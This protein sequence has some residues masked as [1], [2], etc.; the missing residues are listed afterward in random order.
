[1]KFNKLISSSIL[2]SSLILSL[3]F[4]ATAKN[5]VKEDF[6]YVA[7][8]DS[9][10]AGQTPYKELK[11]GYPDYLASRFA[12]SQ[13]NIELENYGFSGYRTTDIL[14]ELYYPTNPKYASLRASIKDAELV[15]IGIGA[16][17]LLANLTKI[18][19][20]PALAP[21]VIQGIGNNLFAI[22]SEI[23]RIKPGTKVYVMGYYNPYPHLPEDQQA[24]LLP[25]LDGLNRVIETVALANGDE[26]VPTAELIKKYEKK[27]VPNPADIHLSLEGY[28]AIAKEFWKTYLK[29]RNS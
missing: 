16:N 2:I 11:A 5:A 12:Q 28:E 4:A 15:T 8:G 6:D 18:Q 24:A 20:N 10:A 21:G 23:D 9:L 17:D 26:F 29:T 7:L 19:Q 3:P 22:L 14:N 25:L 13:Y 27:Y 1:M